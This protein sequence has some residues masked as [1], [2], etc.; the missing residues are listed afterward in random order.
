LEKLVADS[1]YRMP[2]VD[3]Q[4]LRR[5]LRSEQLTVQEFNWAKDLVSVHAFVSMW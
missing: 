1:E 2:G 3:Y 4:L 5:R